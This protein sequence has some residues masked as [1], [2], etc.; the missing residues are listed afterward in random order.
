M[1]TLY[2]CI[3]GDYD[4][5]KEPLNPKFVEGWN[6]VCFTD[7]EITSKHWKI[8]RVNV[9]Q[10]GP[11][12]TARY[13]K[14]MFHKHIQTEFSMWIDATFFINTDLNKWWESR[15]YPPFTTVKHPFDNCIYKDIQSCVRGKKDNVDVLLDQQ[16]LYSRLGIPRQN[17]LIASGI[18]MRQNTQEVRQICSTWWE[19]V[20]GKSCRDQIA[21][22]YAQWRHP[23][24]HQSIGWNYTVEKEFIHI[25]HKHKPWREEK[26]KEIIQ[27]YAAH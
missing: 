21:F 5:L 16:R 4:D 22:G 27:K 12:K 6:L 13:Y 1:K 8:H 9:G 2:T 25:P 17:G 10:Y 20:K 14:I 3:I 24:V 18:L 15:F 23:N 11:A 26:K 19:Q 7:Q